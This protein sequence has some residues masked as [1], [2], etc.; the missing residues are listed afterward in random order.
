MCSQWSQWPLPLGH[1]HLRR[2]SAVRTW[3]QWCP[4]VPTCSPAALWDTSVV[5]LAE[6][7]DL[8]SFWKSFCLL[9]S[10]GEKIIIFKENYWAEHNHLLM[11]VTVEST[12]GSIPVVNLA[13]RMKKRDIPLFHNEVIQL[14]AGYWLLWGQIPQQTGVLFHLNYYYSYGG[15]QIHLFHS[16]LALRETIYA[17]WVGWLFNKTMCYYDCFISLQC[18]E[19]PS[20]TPNLSL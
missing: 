10:A 18:A 3:L 2:L 15:K 19:H 8:R 17:A 4:G 1:S 6:L 9:S 20:S 13:S 11:L 7:D 5:R 16:T 12:A 14:T